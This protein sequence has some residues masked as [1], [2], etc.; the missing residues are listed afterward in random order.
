MCLARKHVDFL[1]RTNEIDFQQRKISYETYIRFCDV[2]ERCRGCDLC[3]NGEQ[4]DILGDCR[5]HVL[6]MFISMKRDS[7]RLYAERRARAQA[8][9]VLSD[10]GVGASKRTAAKDFV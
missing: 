5:V 3:D 2:L 7:E 10:T 4:G 9:A 6:R 8:A 1:G